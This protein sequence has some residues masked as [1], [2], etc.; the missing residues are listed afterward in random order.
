MKIVVDIISVKDYNISMSNKR[1]SR[2]AGFHKQRAKWY[3]V[4]NTLTMKEW[5]EIA[6]K[7]EGICCYCKNYV[8]V[9]FISLDHIIPI[10]KGGGNIKENVVACCY[11]CNVAKCD[12][13]KPNRK[14]KNLPYIDNKGDYIYLASLADEFGVS[15]NSLRSRIKNCDFEI[16]GICSKST[17]KHLVTIETAEKIRSY[18]KWFH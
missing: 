8:G 1:F 6:E 15:T 16:A 2:Q 4:E 18:W 12:R 17:K 10:S 11:P 3:G 7:S 9:E 5:K 13:D 14:T